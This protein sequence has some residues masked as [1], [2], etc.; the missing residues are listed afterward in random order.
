M[1]LRDGPYFSLNA[2][3]DVISVCQK[4]T[5]AVICVLQEQILHLF[6]SWRCISSE[7][8]NVVVSLFAEHKNSFKILPLELK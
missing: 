6:Y 5:T 1:I 7:N 2:A 3:C 4:K 8:R